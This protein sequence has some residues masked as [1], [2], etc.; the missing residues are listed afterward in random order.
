MKRTDPQT[1]RQIIDMVLDSSAGKSEMLGH[2]AS[3]MWPQI[4]GQG[5]NRHTT[6]RYVARGVLHVYIDSAP[7]KTEL[8]FQKTQIIQ[9]INSALG[10]EV[11]KSIAIH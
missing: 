3:Y 11:L 4:V 8:E 2:R 10:Q 7:L 6:R 1:I 9:A 5:V